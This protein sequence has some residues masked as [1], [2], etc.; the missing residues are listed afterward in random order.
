MQFTLA[1]RRIEMLRCNVGPNGNQLTA[2]ENKKGV[3]SEVDSRGVEAAAAASAQAVHTQA[4]GKRPGNHRG[5]L[6]GRTLHK[7]ISLQTDLVGQ[8]NF[9]FIRNKNSMTVFMIR[10]RRVYQN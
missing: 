5:R 7:K 3:F 1:L 4:N 8:L 10:L 9:E 2:L 6:R